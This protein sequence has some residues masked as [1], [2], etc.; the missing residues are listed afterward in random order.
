MYVAISFLVAISAFSIMG[1][2]ECA[3]N[4]LCGDP[5]TWNIPGV[6]SFGITGLISTAFA[7]YFVHQVIIIKGGRP[8]TASHVTEKIAACYLIFPILYGTF[9]F[10]TP[11][12]V[13]ALEEAPLIKVEPQK[14]PSKNPHL[15]RPAPPPKAGGQW[16]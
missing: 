9:I 16:A 11:K 5:K 2:I 12:Q 13:K 4:I 7:F 14:K 15:E 1:T 8:L 10:A 3:H 6:W